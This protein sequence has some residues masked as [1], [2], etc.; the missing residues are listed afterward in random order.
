MT[1]LCS[2]MEFK[3]AQQ[4]CEGSTDGFQFLVTHRHMLQALR[5]A[6]PTHPE[7]FAGFPSFPYAAKDVPSEWQGRFGTGWSDQIV[8]TANT[9]EDIEHNLDRF[10]TEGDLGQFIQCGVMASGASSIHGALHFKWI[11]NGSPVLLGDQ[12]VNTAN[13][14]F[15]KLHGWIDDVWERYR[16]AKG[17]TPEQPELKAALTDQCREMHTLGMALGP[18]M[19]NDKA[20]ALPKE[21][22][23]FHESV[24]PTIEKVCSG[25]HSGSSPEGGLVLGGQ[26]SSADI[27][28]NLVDVQ[29]NRGGQFKRVVRS[30]PDHSWFY[31]KPAGKAADAGCSGTCATQVMPPT[32]MVTLTQSQLD[33]IRKWITDGA[34]AP[35]PG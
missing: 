35:T 22:G 8:Q 26:V 13:Y 21:S 1:D 28:R 2:R 17:L 5:Q 12:A 6:F 7:L 23:F 32:G 4:E 19:G 15:W 3:P 14:M 30:D 29:A 16:V 18:R 27:V 33:A 9:L 34:Q 31:L 11:V 10:P 25:C 20:V 24:R